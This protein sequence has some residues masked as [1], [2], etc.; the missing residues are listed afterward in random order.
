MNHYDTA[1]IGGGVSGL[2]AAIEVA[3]AGKRV[4]VLEKSSHVGGRGIT[5]RKQGA[6][7]N[8]GGHAVYRDGAAYKALHRLGIKLEGGRPG[9]GGSVIWKNRLIPLPGD[10]LKLLTSP[11][12]SF[13]GKMELGR[14]M[15][16]I[17]KVDTTGLGN[18]SLRVWAERHIQDPMV[19]HMFYTLCRTATYSRDLDYQTAAT[20]LHQVRVS[21]SS[22]VLYLDGGWQHI[23]DQLE[24]LAISRGVTIRTGAGVQAISHAD[25][26]VEGVRLGSGEPL[27]V[28]SVISTLAPADNVRL[29]SGAEHTALQRWKEDARPITAAC[30]DLAL[31]RLPVSGRDFVLGLDQPV[32]FSNHS[33]AAKLSEDG[34]V[35]VHLMKYNDVHEQ[36]DPKTAEQLLMST[37]NLIHPGWQQEVV[38]KQF[39]PNLT[40]VHDYPHKAR[41]DDKPGPVVPE[42]R[43]LYVAGDWASHGEMLL[44]AAAASAERAAMQ[45]IRDAAKVQDAVTV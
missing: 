4:I 24:Q 38:A 25:G 6:L 3:Q 34:M 13:A 31:K 36:Y 27:Q 8:L 41:R 22:G 30:L 17:G 20:V 10:P 45:L 28:S 5:V 21:L 2:L 43:R 14:L 35:V 37:M 7:L 16:R 11:L 40:V 32:Y 26:A 42:I 39:L 12:F 29:V 23:V 19:R 18:V 15:T 1:I 33:R 9:N 44:D